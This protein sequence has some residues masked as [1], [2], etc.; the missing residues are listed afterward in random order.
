MYEEECAKAQTFNTNGFLLLLE[1]W[2]ILAIYSIFLEVTEKPEQRKNTGKWIFD[3]DFLYFSHKIVTF[4]ISNSYSIC[5]LSTTDTV[6][7]ASENAIR[8]KENKWVIKN[9]V[10]KIKECYFN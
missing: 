7:L 10:N 8:E 5:V 2:R 1:F 4:Q 3:W 6:N 9:K